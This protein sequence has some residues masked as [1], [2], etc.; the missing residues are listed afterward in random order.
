M[1]LY[2]FNYFKFY[3]H[4]TSDQYKIFAEEMVKWPYHLFIMSS[5]EY[6]PLDVC[7][8]KICL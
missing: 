2:C 4:V 3:V 1:F 8:I 6:Q 5:K 7:S